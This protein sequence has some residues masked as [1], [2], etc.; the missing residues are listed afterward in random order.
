[1]KR[2][3]WSLWGGLCI[4][5]LL[6][7]A[8][9]GEGGPGGR[10]NH[11]GFDIA[12]GACCFGD[13]TCT[14]LKFFEC[15]HEGGIPFRPGTTCD[16]I[17]CPVLPTGACCSADGSCEDVN[18]LACLASGGLPFLP[19]SSCADI[20]CPI[21]PTDACC[22]GD[23]SCADFTVLDCFV[24]GGRPIFGQSC[25]SFDC[26]VLNAVCCFDDGTC[27]ELDPLHCFFQ[28]GTPIIG[29][30]SCDEVD[31]GSGDGESRVKQPTKKTRT[32]E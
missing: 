15:F 10:T 26:P 13:Q 6:T 2:Y 1:M 14:E 19:G 31:C 12:P 22:F 8:T 3:F 11:D 5:L 25:D 27:A 7:A 20:E 24:Q 4:V 32:S 23:G 21:L 17:E 16:K 18:A 29:A 9:K 30:E 28:G